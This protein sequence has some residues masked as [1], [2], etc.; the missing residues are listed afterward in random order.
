M[1]GYHTYKINLD[2]NNVKKID[3]PNGFIMMFDADHARDTDTRRSCECCAGLVFRIA[4]D[5]KMNQ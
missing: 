5:W 3:L 1:D 2:K 4:T